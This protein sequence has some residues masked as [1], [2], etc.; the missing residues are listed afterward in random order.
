MTQ[1]PAA[2]MAIEV[3]RPDPSLSIS[4]LAMIW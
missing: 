3:N 1:G 4:G 2:L